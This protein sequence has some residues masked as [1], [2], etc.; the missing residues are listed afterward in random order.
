[1]CLVVPSSKMSLT[2]EVVFYICRQRDRHFYLLSMI[3]CLMFLCYDGFLLNMDARLD[4][5]CVL[6]LFFFLFAPFRFY[7]FHLISCLEL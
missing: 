4:G 2:T 7:A 6:F 5:K 1:M 3:L